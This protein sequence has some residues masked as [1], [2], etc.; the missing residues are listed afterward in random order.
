MFNAASKLL[1][2]AQA[3]EMCTMHAASL[4]LLDMIHNVYLGILAKARC[5]YHWPRRDAHSQSPHLL[6]VQLPVFP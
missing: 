2:H 5:D 4:T 6:H 3:T 1:A